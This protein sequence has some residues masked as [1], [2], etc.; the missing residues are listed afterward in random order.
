[1]IATKGKILQDREHAAHLL[2]LKVSNYK[3]T[4]AIVVGVGSGGSSVGLALAR[5]LNLSFEVV[6]CREMKHPADSKKTIGSVSHG[7][8]VMND[9]I[10]DIPQD[11]L[12]HQ[13]TRLQCEIENDYRIVYGDQPRP[14]FQFKTVIPVGDLLNS[15]DCLL[16][17]IKVIKSHMPLRVIVAVPV[18]APHAA[19]E[20]A[21]EVN[22]LFFVHM[23]SGN[24]D[25]NSFYDHYPPIDLIEI[26]NSITSVR[27]IEPKAM[28]I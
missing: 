11:F 21:G 28:A 8:V 23:E 19:A 24:L 22:D 7:M 18:V 27:R 12:A 15:P 25:G 16:A 5:E 14:S 1:M 6:F 13:V 10:S 3:N 20:I 26:K 2:A 9:G 17:G 4:N